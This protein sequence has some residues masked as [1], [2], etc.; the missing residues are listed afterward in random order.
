MKNVL[1]I[2]SSLIDLFID[3]ENSHKIKGEGQSVTL[4]LGDKIPVDIKAL[5]LGGNGGNVASAL[6]KLGTPTSFY[7]YLGEDVLS[8]YIKTVMEKEEVTLYIEPEETITGSLSL[9]FNFPTD[10][11]IF[12]HHNTAS[13][14]FDSEKLTA[15]PDILFL[16]SIGK[17][18]EDAYRKALEYA[19]IS[20]IPII[21]SPGS[22]QL[23]EMTET[24]IN[25]VHES[26]MLFCNMEEARL[27]FKAIS[28][29]D[30]LEV[31]GLLLGLKTNGFE[32]ISVTD[33]ENGAYAVDSAGVVYKIPT[34][35]PEGHEKTGAGDAYAGAFLASY[36]EN[37]PI[38]ECMK[39][40]TL[41][42]LG[43]MSHIGAHT[44]QLRKSEMDEKVWKVELK[45]EII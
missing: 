27:I 13:H 40:G 5:S 19:K 42:S 32:L 4:E 6:R 9:I 22:Q 31:K 34:M 24:F 39:R 37:M 25:A 41:N 44:G 2:G 35:K 28:G 23:A 29:D 16:S 1:V 36:L 8:S 11:I 7:T 30:I 20:S 33:G 17:E 10:R 38:E 45:A 3:V 15:S 18:W 12:S 14:S 21:L 43:V 26:K